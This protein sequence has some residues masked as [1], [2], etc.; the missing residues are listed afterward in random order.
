M[1]QEIN[2]K[3]NFHKEVCIFISMADLM[4]AQLYRF[5]YTTYIVRWNGKNAVLMQNKLNLRLL[6]MSQKSQNDLQSRDN[7]YEKYNLPLVMPHTY[8]IYKHRP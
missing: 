1:T 7:A 6:Y 4:Q 3:F 5:I 2:V 8:C